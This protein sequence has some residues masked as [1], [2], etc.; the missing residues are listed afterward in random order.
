MSYSAPASLVSAVSAATPT[1]LLADFSAPEKEATERR[2]ATT[3][4][5]VRILGSDAMV[6]GVLAPTLQY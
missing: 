1:L 6:V 4:P 3:R 2:A 5:R